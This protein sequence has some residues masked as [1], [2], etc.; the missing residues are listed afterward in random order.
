MDT[1]CQ[2][3]SCQLE[4]PHCFLNRQE[5]V[6]LKP[7]WV[8][9][10]TF[11]EAKTIYKHLILNG[12]I[13]AF[14]TMLFVTDLSARPL[15]DLPLN[16]AID[17]TQ[18]HF[19]PTKVWRDGGVLR[20]KSTLRKILDEHHLYIDSLKR[21]IATHVMESDEAEDTLEWAL[22]HVYDPWVFDSSNTLQLAL[23]N[24]MVAR[25]SDYSGL[26]IL[27]SLASFVNC[28]FTMFTFDSLDLS[29]VTFNNCKFDD[30]WF[31]GSSLYST[32][33]YQNSTFLNAKFDSLDMR[34]SVFIDCDLRGCSFANSDL[35]HAYF[36]GTNLNRTDFRHANLYR[37]VY[38]PTNDP[39][40]RNILFAY[41]LDYLD[42]ASDPIPL[43]RLRQQFRDIGFRLAERQVNCALKRHYPSWYETALFDFTCNYG[44]D[45]VRPLL[46]W[47]KL[48][49]IYIWVYF[50]ELSIP[51][52]RPII[53]IYRKHATLDNPEVKSTVMGE[54]SPFSTEFKVASWLERIKSII[55]LLFKSVGISLLSATSIGFRDIT[56]AQWVKRLLPIEL[57]IRF[58]GTSRILSGVQSLL[59]MYLVA[60]SFL[61][62]FTRVFDY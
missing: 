5:A 1:N 29:Y 16:E 45:F 24:T 23:L 43:I 57:E 58:E 54:R 55:K 47:V 21:I 10:N 41:N 15:W 32:R 11:L 13:L 34:K 3:E 7:S 6:E 39:H 59:S 36:D 50:A 37:M 33:F 56:I 30:A 28:D 53:F 8:I 60:L 17:S 27:D 38:Q 22:R 40:W 61:S 51:T 20:S 44:A 48:W 62:Y 52:K 26:E 4:Y 2:C 9:R 14:G 49:F 42:Y 25:P 19:M 18:L 35:S 46:L 12:L 31:T